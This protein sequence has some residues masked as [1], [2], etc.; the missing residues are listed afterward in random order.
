M[1]L[2][3]SGRIDFSDIRAE[4]NGTDPVRL[5][6]YYR[7]GSLVPNIAA[8]NNIPTFGQNKLSNFYGTTKF[9]PKFYTLVLNAKMGID[10]SDYFWFGWFNTADPTA[11]YTK[12]T[13]RNHQRGW[14]I[15]VDWSYSIATCTNLSEPLRSV[16]YGTAVT[17]NGS[18]GL[19]YDTNYKLPFNIPKFDYVAHTAPDP[20]F[21]YVVQPNKVM[22]LLEK[23]NT[24]TYPTA[25]FYQTQNGSNNYT[26]IALMDDDPPASWREGHLRLT[27]RWVELTS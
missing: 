8:N 5:S 15:T 2:Q 24:W 10:G 4:F 6:N 17:T 1:A 21:G 23:I 18:I 25:S 3:T 11:P 12:I 14:S 27:Y 7:G 22:I 9:L 26:T 13:H 16:S 19:S 20:T